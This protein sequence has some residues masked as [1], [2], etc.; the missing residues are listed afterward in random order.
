M[1]LFH[2]SEHLF[3]TLQTKFCASFESAD[4]HATF[5]SD[6]WKHPD[7]GGGITRVL[8]HGTI[9]E[10]AGIN[11]SSVVTPLSPT[12]ARR[13]N[14]PAEQIHATGISLV[15][16]PLSPM[17]PVVHMNLRHL[18]LASGDEWFGGGMDLTPWYLYE[19]D[20]VHFHSTIRAACDR[21]DRNFYPNAKK[22]CDEYFFI[23]HR[24][25]ARGI[26]GIFFDYQRENLST[27]FTFITDLGNSFPEMYLPILERRKAETW[28][29]AQREWQLVR[30]GRYV[31]FN[32]VYDRGTLFGLESK[33]RTE[34]ILM[35]LPPEVKWEY[36]FKTEPGSREEELVKVLQHPRSWI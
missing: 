15:L 6:R 29:A 25:E 7:G 23:R 2:D 24:N 26:G 33:G 14:V 28:T 10:K 4:G 17:V 36:D 32:L 19:E 3:E 16:H 21:H 1:Q 5:S 8:R 31:E 12:M 13:M 22:A 20:A 35:S 34:S 11:F 9:F 18:R 30:R 27:M